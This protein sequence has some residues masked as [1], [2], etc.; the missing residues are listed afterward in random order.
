M[1]E[2]N[3]DDN[4]T[5]SPVEFT[6]LPLDYIIS[7][8]L[9]STINAHKLAAQTSLNY[10]KEL[11][12]QD[13]SFEREITENGQQTGT[14]KVTAPLLAVTKVP[15]LNFDSL[16][17]DFEY[18]ISQV[19]TEKKSTTGQGSLKLGTSPFL[20]KFVNVGLNGSI[21]GSKSTTN[22]INKSGSLDIKLHASE[23]PMPEG[24]NKII[25]WLTQDMKEEILP[26]A[27]NGDNAGGVTPTPADPVTPPSGDDGQ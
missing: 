26:A 1:A 5:F 19:Y 9:M 22:T 21:N 20:S 16:D 24:L 23:A 7:A 25:N 27:G 4:V 18:Q 3:N 6:K 14:R 10:V 8:P 17:I 2:K 15:N 12:G 11:A 13:V